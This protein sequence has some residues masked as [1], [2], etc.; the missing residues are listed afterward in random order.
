MTRRNTPAACVQPVPPPDNQADAQALLD[1]RILIDLSGRPLSPHTCP[2][3]HGHDS[4]GETC[5][6]AVD[7]PTCGAQGGVRVRC[8]RPSGHDGAWHTERRRA[9]AR[10]DDDREH[11]GDPTVPAPWPPRTQTD[12]ND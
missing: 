3:C 7:C 5:P 9:A 12:R 2:T 10:V 8:Q 11:R 6:A 4:I 1:A